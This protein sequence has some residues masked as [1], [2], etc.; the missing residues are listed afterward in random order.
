MFRK[1][2]CVMV[3]VDN[4]EAGAQFYAEVFGLKRLWQD[5]E[6]VGMGMAETDAEIVLHTM[7][8]PKEIGVHYLVDDVATAVEQYRQKGC[9]IREE[10]FEVAIGRCA[11]LEDAFGNVLCVIDMS[12]GARQAT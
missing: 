5:S 3:P 12:K 4:L 10:P 1:I 11:V 2:D 9:T 6:S 7:D 8:L